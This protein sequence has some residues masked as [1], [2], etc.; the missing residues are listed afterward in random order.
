M[1]HASAP[2]PLALAPSHEDMLALHGYPHPH[3]SAYDHP[4]YAPSVASS[5]SSTSTLPSSGTK[6]Y[7]SAPAK[8]FMCTGFGDCRM[9]F[10]RSEHLARHIRKHT[11]ER[12][13]A[14]HCSK[15][16]SRLDNL[17]QHAQTVHSAPEDKP[18]N[19]RMMRALAG[20]NA[21]MMAGVRGRRRYGTGPA[22]NSADSH[23]LSPLPSPLPTGMIYSPSSYA[24]S[25]SPPP[26]LSSASSGSSSASSSPGISEAAFP[27]E[28]EL[29]QG[30]GHALYA[31]YA[32][33]V[34]PSGTHSLPASPSYPSF[35]TGVQQRQPAH[36]FTSPSYDESL[37]PPSYRYLPQTAPP[38]PTEPSDY[39]SA[40]SLAQQQVM[41]KQEEGLDL[42]EFY[43]AVYAEPVPL[44]AFSPSPSL[45][46]SSPP[47]SP[48]YYQLSAQPQG[49]PEHAH[50]YSEA[51]EEG[52]T[53]ADYYRAVQEAEFLY[54][55]QHGPRYGHA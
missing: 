14:C 16:F 2:P 6:R 33:G 10:S 43:R 36:P 18:L 44:Q 9:I 55:Q 45:P 19:E 15:S 21:S 3:Q 22:P 20:I 54:A 49:Y 4:L 37:A 31:A 30:S 27:Y 24:S 5:S 51:D 48:P 23:S 12:P 29:A 47:T 28:L 7:R 32:A 8:Q 40:G 13:F 50:A 38:M 17:R 42:D 25:S 11:G 52:M 26:G 46:P 1:Y 35:P 53:N 34:H 39:L 41:V